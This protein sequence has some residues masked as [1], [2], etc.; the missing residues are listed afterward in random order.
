MIDYLR[1]KFDIESKLKNLSS[2]NI[3]VGEDDAESLSFLNN[4]GHAKPKSDKY[5]DISPRFEGILTQ[6]ST[7]LEMELDDGDVEY[8]K[9]IL[10]AL[11]K[12]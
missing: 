12:I 8:I 1:R 7:L 3:V 11:G 4:I 9:D 5:A 6:L 10:V 2:F